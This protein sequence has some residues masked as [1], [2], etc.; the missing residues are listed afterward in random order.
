MS[1]VKQNVDAFA[2]DSGWDQVMADAIPG[3]SN[4][5]KERIEVLSQMNACSDDSGWEQVM[6]DV[7]LRPNNNTDNIEEDEGIESLP[8]TISDD[9]DDNAGSDASNE[10]GEV[11]SE[12]VDPMLPYNEDMLATPPP[13]YTDSSDEDPPSQRP[14]WEM[15]IHEEIK[16]LNREE[17]KKYF[18]NI[19]ELD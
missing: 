3:P 2:N 19:L 14:Y 18:E 13:I 16:K 12:E 9:S 8:I 7:V 17:K 11:S 5:N 6:A 10:S 1:S 4:N 15:I